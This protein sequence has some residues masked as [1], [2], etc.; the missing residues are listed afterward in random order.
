MKKILF[1]ANLDSFFIKFLIP[2]LKFFKDK[3]YEIHIASKEDGSQIPYYDKKFNVNFARSLNLKQNIESYKQMKDLLKKE[4]YDIIFCHTPFG[5]AITRLAAKKYRKTGT[6]VIYVAHGFHFFKGAPLFNWLTFY[7]AEKYLS[8]FTD[9]LLTINEEDYNRANKK[10][11]KC[12]VKYMPGIGLDVSKFDFSM[13]DN[14]KQEL[15]ASLNLKED[16]FVGIYA[17]EISP[18]KR[19]EWLIRSLEKTIKENNKIHILLPGRDSMNGKCHELVKSLGLENNIHLIGLR[20]DI[21][22]LLK[23]VDFA[24]SS[25]K[26]EGLPVNIMEAMYTGLPIVACDCRGVSNLIVNN[27]NGYLISLNDPKMY[28]EKI[29][30]LYKGFGLKEAKMIDQE[31]IKEYLIDNVVDKFYEICKEYID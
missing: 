24:T 6:K 23:I 30:S 11:K 2:Y 18:N 5:A 10:F 9:I 28:A 29:E 14:E 31:V 17:A 21:P 1:A 16:D 26:R 8:K 27:K 7:P 25:S 13:T 19:Q 4:H 15:R 3:N 20:N 22:R 12:N